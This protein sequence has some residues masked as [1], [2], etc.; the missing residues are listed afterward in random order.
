MCKTSQSVLITDTSSDI[1]RATARAFP[2]NGWTVY[3]TARS[4]EDIADLDNEGCET[5][6]PYMVE[7]LLFWQSS[8]GYT[9]RKGNWIV[10]STTPGYGQLGVIEDVTPEKLAFYK[11]LFGRV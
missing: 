9:G 2:D 1:G 10:S 7:Q 3:A 8:T 11:L 5:A 6:V 4:V